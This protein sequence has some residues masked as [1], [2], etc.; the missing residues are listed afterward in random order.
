MYMLVTVV[1]GSFGQTMVKEVSGIR[2]FNPEKRQATRIDASPSIIT[3]NSDAPKPLFSSTL[4][5]VNVTPSFT[6]F[7]LIPDN[8]IYPRPSKKGYAVLGYFPKGDI[9]LSA[10]YRIIDKQAL[11]AGVWAQLNRNFYH[12][13][14]PDSDDKYRITTTDVAT[15]ANLA[16]QARDHG[17]LTS[18]L[19]YTYGHFN[20][21]LGNVSPSSQS[22]NNFTFNGQ[23]DGRAGES[24]RYGASASIS[25]F[26]YSN[27]IIPEGFSIDANDTKPLAETC[28]RTDAYATFKCS[29]K[30]AVSLNVNYQQTSLNRFYFNDS[31]Q[32]KLLAG[33]SINKGVLSVTPRVSFNGKKMNGYLGFN[34]AFATQDASGSKIGLATAWNWL[35]S[36]YFSINAN[37]ESRPQI[38]SLE[39]LYHINRYASPLSTTG[40]SYIPVDLR[41]SFNMLSFK[42]FSLSAGIGFSHADNWVTPTI[43]DGMQAFEITDLSTGLF[44]A[45]AAYRYG[46]TFDIETSVTSAT[47]DD[48]DKGYYLWADRAKTVVNASMNWRPFRFLSIAV[49][50]QYRA[51]RK[52]TSYSLLDDSTVNDCRFL[53]LNDVSNLMLGAR[54]TINDTFGVYGRVEGITQGKY[55]LV[56]GLPGQRLR[57]LLGVSVKF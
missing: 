29:R 48:S 27:A 30:V 8:P 51:G 50:Y 42:G 11:N 52:I 35:L 3:P 10:G 9:D 12:G 7:S 31:F 45:K 26:S 47:G 49:G 21:P 15:G 24:F 33:P 6:P 34:M 5:E 18:S 13:Q 1:L 53:N 43:I 23:W 55:L 32:D 37:V 22:V 36:N 2:D 57:P 17:V 40:I 19:T 28:W 44:F 16:W 25:R 4:M 54:W 38:N 56:S 41:L 14:F 46:E 20:Y 39:Q